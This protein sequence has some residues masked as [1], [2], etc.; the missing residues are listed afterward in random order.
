V[1]NE[2]RYGEWEEV[3]RKA[4]ELWTKSVKIVET[5]DDGK[6]ALEAYHHY[7]EINDFELAGKILIFG[8][9]NKFEKGEQLGKALYRL[10]WLQKIN[11]CICNIIN[12]I[13]LPYTLCHIYNIFGNV[14]WLQGDIND[15]VKFHAMSSNIASEALDSSCDEREKIILQIMIGISLF[16]QG[17]CKMELG[18]LSE[19]L[20]DFNSTLSFI[21]KI[22]PSEEEDLINNSL[23]SRFS[24]IGLIRECYLYIAFINSSL[25]N[26]KQARKFINKSNPFPKNNNTWKRDYSL[27][28]IGATYTKL[29]DIDNAFNFYKEIIAFTNE[30]LNYPQVKANALT[31]LAEIYRIQ[32]DF[33]KALSH[34]SESIELLDKIGARCDLAEAHYQL[35]L[36]YQKMGETKKSHTNFNE[37]IRLFNEMEAPKQVEKVEKAKKE[38]ID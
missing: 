5:L 15:A 24:Y 14:K 9:D 23:T 29:G 11:I 31:G 26:Q 20:N 25:G 28:Y 32:N 34:H 6:K 38:N 2:K 4:S 27:V 1:C 22:Y 35:G 12:K 37:A 16:N 21:R 7:V 3:N 33:E 36:T 19:A 8:R 17:L 13:K 18:D 10:G 30:I